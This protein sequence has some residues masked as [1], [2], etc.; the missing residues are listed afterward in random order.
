[1]R[2]EEESSS[3]PVYHGEH[4]V[5]LETS[6]DAPPA[7]SYDA[8]VSDSRFSTREEV[9]TSRCRPAANKETINSMSRLTAFRKILSITLHYW[10]ILLLPSV[11]AGFAVKY[12]NQDARVVFA[13][14]FVAAIPI[15]LFLSKA[16]DEILE[17]AGDT[18]G[19][20]IYMTF[21][22]G[23]QRLC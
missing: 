3:R 13:I 10:E 9:V 5:V 11:P 4:H 18:L 17:R 6:P 20:L 23:S 19:S 8:S 15:A 2:E 12:T 16:V 22:Y 21:R 7:R 1:M 14:N